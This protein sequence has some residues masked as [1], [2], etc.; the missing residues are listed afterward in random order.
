MQV[1]KERYA[2]IL[3]SDE[4]HWNMLRLCNKT[5]R[6]THVFVR[7]NLVGPTQTIKLLFYVKRPIKQIRGVAD[8]VERLTGD[9]V[10]L[11]EKFGTESCFESFAEYRAFIE[12]RERVTFVRFRNFKEL[13]NPITAEMFTS[14]VGLSLAPR[15]G[16]YL[17]LEETK[18]LLH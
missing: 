10:G 17:N 16:R 13:E 3:I 4:K 12:G 7:K 5:N 6:S 1:E 11:W 18:Q 9:D 15:G 8:F 14:A 2:F